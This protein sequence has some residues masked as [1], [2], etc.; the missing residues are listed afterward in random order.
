MNFLLFNL[1]SDTCRIFINEEFAVDENRCQET[2]DKY[3]NPLCFGY[4]PEGDCY[5]K[6]GYTR[7]SDNSICL[8]T[9]NILCRLRM[10]PTEGIVKDS[11]VSFL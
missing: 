6:K 11:E 2:C 7:L 10:P 4:A 1:T 5:C 8:P 3:G 9:N